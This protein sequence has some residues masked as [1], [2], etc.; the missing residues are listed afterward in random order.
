MDRSLVGRTSI[1]SICVASCACIAISMTQEY[2]QQ[3]NLHLVSLGLL[4]CMLYVCAEER[5]K[6]DW[7]NNMRWCVIR[8]FFLC[9]K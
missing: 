9:L 4:L 1:Y 6:A 3:K 7:D 8:L 5:C 2:E